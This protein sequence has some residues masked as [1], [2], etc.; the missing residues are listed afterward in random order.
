LTQLIHL[1]YSSAEAYKFSE[2]DLIY[3][4]AKA[5]QYNR[6]ID[7]T[8]ILL[9]TEGSFFQ[10]LEGEEVV[11]D[12]LFA[13]ISQ[14]KRHTKTVIIMREPIL[15][16][17]FGEWTMGYANVTSQEVGQLT[18][19]ND[20]F[21][22]ASCFG[23]LDQGRAK[24][25][26]SA[27][28]EG[29]WRTK[30]R[31]LEDFPRASSI[32]EQPLTEQYS[33]ISFAFQPIID[34]NSSSII[35]FEAI[36]RSLNNQ[37]LQKFGEKTHTDVLSNFDRHCCTIA[38]G[39]ATRL[40]LQSGLS[41]NFIARDIKDTS[42]SIRVIMDTAERHNI[43]LNR[44]I[45]EIDQDKLIGDPAQL[46]KAIEEFRIAGLKISIS[47]FGAGRTGLNLLESYHPEIISLNINLVKGIDSNIPRQAIVRGV[48]QICNDLGIDIIA[49]HVETLNEYWWLRDEGINLFQG[50][51]F[52]KPAFEELPS[53]HYPA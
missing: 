13:K 7:V 40:G 45:L 41:L 16:R 28:K 26:L 17:S 49:K 39:M 10:I 51:L 53:A 9:Y 34:A 33:N 20:F 18:G 4:L 43:E 5:R 46:V 36:V 23:E 29:L 35:S 37:I 11:I 38:I 12:A 22:Y 14:D 3:L 2:D 6:I 1:I 25:I 15:K 47:H 27:F 30:V 8:G 24:K 19:I 44:V 48:I 42:V 21:T 32:I 31:N 50:D 52:A